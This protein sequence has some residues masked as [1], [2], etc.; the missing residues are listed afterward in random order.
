MKQ[1]FLQLCVFA[2]CLLLPA[3][4]YGQG[5][6]L[7]SLQD[8]IA[9]GRLEEAEEA[10]RSM[11]E[12]GETPEARDL[13][14][15]VLSRQGR[16]VEARW[17]YERAL[18]LRSDYQPAR[19]HLARLHLLEGRELQALVELRQAAA[20]GL[21]ERDLAMKLAVAEMADGRPAEAEVQL[22]S[23][24]ER[25][26]SAQAWLYLAKIR[27][28]ATSDKTA[29]MAAAR[30]AV[31]EAR[32]LAPNAE[33]VLSLAAKLALEAG[34]P[35]LALADLDALQRILPEEP[36]YLQ[37]L[38]AARLQ[39][40]DSAA[41]VEALLK[42]RELEANALSALGVEGVEAGRTGTLLALGMA[43][44]GQKRFVEAESALREHLARQPEDALALGAL[45]EAEAGQ[46]KDKVAAE[47]VARAL[48]GEPGQA[49]G[50]RVLGQL[51]SR[52]QRWAEAAAAL[53]KAVA[54]E[55]DSPRAHYQLSLVYSR[56]GEGEKSAQHLEL[57]RQGLAAM[58]NRLRALGLSSGDAGD[59][60]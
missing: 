12:E 8:A 43:L 48:A 15:L 41:A 47:H 55:P 53:E 27:A 30:Q 1:S 11:L 49:I 28:V 10:L 45:A 35:A 25:F 36:R 4:G 7:P 2:F 14:G 19:Q 51:L 57:Y 20:L 56:L 39:L 42:A 46:S 22:L 60:P 38:G 40:G 29:A 3:L 16:L 44:N 50:N 13:L 31:E 33:E 5:V 23:L 37:L 6:D 52:Q 21:L 32:Q 18:A 59:E 17:E 9:G 26:D 58:E 24:A 54:A 34:E